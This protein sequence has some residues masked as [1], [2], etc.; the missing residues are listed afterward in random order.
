MNKN[1]AASF[2]LI[3]SASLVTLYAAFKYFNENFVKELVFLYLVLITSIAFAECIN[4][5]MENRCPQVL[6]SVNNKKCNSIFIL[7]YIVITI[8]F[9]VRMCDLIS[10]SIACALGIIL[11]LFFNYL[12]IFYYFNGHWMINNLL[13]IA[14]VIFVC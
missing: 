8:Q 11:L 10:Y 1:D 2:P 14:V 13:G 12:G 9:E 5:Y 6:L 3:A 4:Y 7:F